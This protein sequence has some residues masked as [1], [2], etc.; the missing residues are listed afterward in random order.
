MD[1]PGMGGESG[2]TRGG[3]GA[4]T[5]GDGYTRGC[6]IKGLGMVGKRAVRILLEYFLVHSVILPR[7]TVVPG[8]YDVSEETR[9]ESGTEC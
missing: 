6:Y 9:T 4:Y 3:W 7:F 8:L 5:R 1:V 2:Y